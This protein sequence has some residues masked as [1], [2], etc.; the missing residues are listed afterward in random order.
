[1]NY[2]KTAINIMCGAIPFRLA[3]HT[4]RTKLFNAVNITARQTFSQHGQDI[5]VRE[6]FNILGIARPTYIDLG[7]HH[8]YTHSNTALLYR[9]G[10]RGINVEADPSLIGSFRRNRR[11]DVNLCVGCGREAGTLPYYVLYTGCD[12]NGF[13]KARIDEFI[14]GH[15]KY[16]ITQ[17]KNVPVVTLSSIIEEHAGGTFPDLLD[18]DL[19]GLDYDVL[20]SCDLSGNG[21]KIAIIESADNDAIK[22]LMHEY[23]YFSYCKMGQ[24]M[25]FARNEYKEKLY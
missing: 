18:M 25:I 22:K 20:R 23:G 10:S 3:R 7:A 5:L 4:V 15:P 24:D 6:M 2:K 16:A 12:C 8:P 11:H 1:M 14:A 13:D 21:P 19:E 17:I 9:A